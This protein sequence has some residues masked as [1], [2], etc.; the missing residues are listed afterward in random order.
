VPI[1]PRFLLDQTRGALPTRL[2]QNTPEKFYNNPLL[3]NGSGK[4]ANKTNERKLHIR[5]AML[6]VRQQTNNEKPA[7]LKSAKP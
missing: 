1:G 7:P 3:R 2:N 5:M 4:V 6:G